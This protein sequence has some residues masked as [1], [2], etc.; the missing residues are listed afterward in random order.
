MFSFARDEP[1]EKAENPVYPN[2]LTYGCPVS[3]FLYKAFLGMNK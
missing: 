1:K 2:I 3:I